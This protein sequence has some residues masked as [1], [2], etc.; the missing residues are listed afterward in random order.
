MKWLTFN[1][2]INSFSL[3]SYSTSGQVTK[4]L[5]KALAFAAFR[6][7]TGGTSGLCHLRFVL[8]KMKTE[9]GLVV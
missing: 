5:K 4:M 8:K 6:W 1:L 2:P 3:L 9:G 7:A